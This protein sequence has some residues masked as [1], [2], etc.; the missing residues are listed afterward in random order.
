MLH[1][2]THTQ[3]DKWFEPLF[4]STIINTDWVV[5]VGA[6]GLTSSPVMVCE[7]CICELFYTHLIQQEALVS[8]SATRKYSQW[9]REEVGQ[10][11]TQ[12]ELQ[13]KG[14]NTDPRQISSLNPSGIWTFR[15]VVAPKPS[16]VW[17]VVVSYLWWWAVC[18]TS[19]VYLS[20]RHSTVLVWVV[21]C[22]FT[23][24]GWSSWTAGCFR[25]HWSVS[26][27]SSR[28]SAS[29]SQDHVPDE[30][31]VL[32]LLLL[33]TLTSSSSTCLSS[34][35]PQP[36]SLFSSGFSPSSSSISIGACSELGASAH[37]VAPAGSREV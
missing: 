25:F 21:Q 15:W 18:V 20:H 24:S 27:C 34:T 11:D 13:L 17:T 7:L 8:V 12:L 26:R 35:T 16:S 19:L 4:S 10:R 23:S 31:P 36:P 2:H 30:V 6:L 32:L 1:T 33:F 5:F 29:D 37:R 3:T 9:N 22:C 14:P 28:C